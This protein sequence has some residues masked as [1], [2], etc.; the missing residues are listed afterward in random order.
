MDQTARVHPGDQV[1]A[2]GGTS[3]TLEYLST[4]NTGHMTAAAVENHINHIQGPVRVQLQRPLT[5]ARKSLYH[6][7]L[8]ELRLGV[9]MV[10]HRLGVQ[11]FSAGE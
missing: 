8:S 4:D 5:E 10:F 7:P 2:F 1:V 9:Y 6:A 11:S 3:E